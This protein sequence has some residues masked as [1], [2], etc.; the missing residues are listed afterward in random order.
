MVREYA[1]MATRDNNLNVD[2]TAPAGG[3]C[4]CVEFGDIRCCPAR[5]RRVLFGALSGVQRRRPHYAC[6]VAAVA[7]RTLRRMIP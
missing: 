1:L 2:H 3:S 7:T 4:R 6:V 5:M